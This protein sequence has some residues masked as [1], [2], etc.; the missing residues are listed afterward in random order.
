MIPTWKSVQFIQLNLIFADLS[1]NEIDP[2]I[3]NKIKYYRVPAHK[4]QTNFIAHAYI[5]VGLKIM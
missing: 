2:V 3:I 5:A 1:K 4:I